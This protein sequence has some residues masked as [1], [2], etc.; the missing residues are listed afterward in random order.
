MPDV[1][2]SDRHGP[3][4]NPTR[5]LSPTSDMSD[6]S[7][8]GPDPSPDMRQPDVAVSDSHEQL[9]SVPEFARQIGRSE[10]T[11]QRWVRRGSI[12]ATMIGGGA[13]IPASELQRFD[14]T[15]DTD[16][17]SP[18]SDMSDRRNMS[19]TRVGV[20]A[21]A[22]PAA[23]RELLER[24]EAAMVRLGWL[25][26]ELQTARR[27]LTDGG[28]Q[29]STLQSK[30]EQ[31]AD[32]RRRAELE[33]AAAAALRL[34]AEQR[35]QESLAQ[36]EALRTKLREEESARQAALEADKARPWWRRM[37]R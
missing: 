5:H 18:T 6:V 25:E 29:T 13:R 17:M 11:V 1:L 33:A 4:D 3:S 19:P 37:F 28:T 14:P 34:A 32:G 8:V 20:S 23:Y 16:T 36:L 27:A 15:S 12:S 21:D 7:N 35:E 9:L 26:S 24:H 2:T 10:R 30:L 22:R 31:E